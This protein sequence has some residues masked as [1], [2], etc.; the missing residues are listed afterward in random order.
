[1]KHQ[2]K[3]PFLIFIKIN[4]IIF[5]ERKKKGKLLIMPYVAKNTV[6]SVRGKT[7]KEVVELLNAL[8]AEQQEWIFTC[9]GCSDFWMHQRG[10]ENAITFDTEKYID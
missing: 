9:C 2:I 10:T 4:V 5:I 8:P 7:V 1:M 6:I 3:S